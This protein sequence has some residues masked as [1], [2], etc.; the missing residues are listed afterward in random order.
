MRP[1]VTAGP[2]PGSPADVELELEADTPP[3]T[4]NPMMEIEATI[5]K[6]RIPE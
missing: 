5:N 4:N 3:I 2:A 1:P 6:E